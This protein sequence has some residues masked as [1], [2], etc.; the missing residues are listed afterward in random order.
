MIELHLAVSQEIINLMLQIIKHTIPKKN[1]TFEIKYDK[2]NNYYYTEGLIECDKISMKVCSVLHLLN[3]KE[4]TVF[5]ARQL[6]MLRGQN[7]NSKFCFITEPCL[8]CSNSC[9]HTPSTYGFMLHC[10]HHELQVVNLIKEYTL[11]NL[12]TLWI[13]P[14]PDHSPTMLLLG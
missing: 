6:T 9:C 2:I 5:L 7:Y 10:V 13:V 1:W 4:I 11:T 12:F 8:W 3:Q 14:S